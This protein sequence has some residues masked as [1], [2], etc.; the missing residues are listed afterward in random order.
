MG[1]LPSSLYTFPVPVLKNEI[2]FSKTGTGL[3]SVLSFA[4][5]KIS[6]NLTENPSGIPAG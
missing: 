1:N 2:S 5:R 4:T 6:P 3:G